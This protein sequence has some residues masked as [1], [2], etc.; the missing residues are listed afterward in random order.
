M[1]PGVLFTRSSCLLVVVLLL[2]GAPIT[3]EP[4]LSAED[5]KY[6]DKLLAGCHFD[7]TGAERVRGEF[8]F[9]SPWGGTGT[10]TRDG[11]MVREKGKSRVYF[12]DGFS[13]PAPDK[14]TAI[15]FVDACKE[16]YVEK[17]KKEDERDEVF[18]RMERT[19]RGV[20]GDSDLSFAVWLHKLGHDELAAKALAVARK[21]AAR[22]A[23]NRRDT[24]APDPR[25]L[26]RDDLAWEAFAGLVHAYVNHDDEL[27]LA[28][29][30]HFFKQYPDHFVRTREYRQAEQIVGELNRRKREGRFG[31]EGKRL[32]PT[33]V[34]AE[35]NKKIAT[36][37]TA[38]D[39]VDARQSGQPG[40]VDLGEDWRVMALIE[41]GE[42]AV[43]AL[44]DAF[45]TDTRLTRSV[46]FWRDFSHSRTVLSV[47]EAELVALMS[48]L[49]VQ[50]FEPA[51]T[52][53][54]FTARGEKTAKE[55]A[56]QLRAYWDTYGKFPFDERMMKILTDPKASSSACR[57]AAEN[58]ATIGNR[59][60][61]GTTVWT[62]GWFGKLGEKANPVIAKFSNPTAAEAMLRALDRELKE[63]A[64]KDEDA[65]WKQR[66]MDRAEE[67]YLDALVILGDKRIALELAKRCTAASSLD[68]RRRFALAAFRLGEPKQLEELAKAFEVGS[69]RLTG[70]DVKPDRLGSWPVPEELSGL[71]FTLSAV[72]TP[73]TDR[74][75]FA[76]AD[77]KHPYHHPTVDV[78]SDR[79][80][81]TDK[82]FWYRHPYWLLLV[83]KT[84]DDTT[85]TGTV[86]K[87]EGNR[88]TYKAKDGSG[89]SGIPEELADPN[90]RKVEASAR[91]CDKVAERVSD[92]VV[93]LP[94]FHLMRTDSE[95]TLKTMKEAIDRYSTRFRQITPEERDVFRTS[96]FEPTFIPS[97]KPLTQA[98]TADDVSS[99]RA[100]FHL[101]G[102]GKAAGLALPAWVTLK[103]EGN[104]D[105]IRGLAVQAEIGP[106]GTIVYGVIFK[107][108]MKTV[109]T[110]DI[111]K[112][113]P[114]KA[115]HEMEA[116]NGGPEKK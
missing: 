64:S 25:E 92:S 3:A 15:N 12:A 4:K 14:F 98:A 2:L 29:G 65:G 45:D 21:Q 37:I 77:P 32:V 70:L 42:P 78:L 68:T 5:A 43:P 31:P 72:R 109:P 28:Y 111:E 113:E 10:V 74:A 26:L 61:I 66:K 39:E 82:R 51:S 16:R 87:I 40:G 59:R 44:I 54:N 57:E 85:P 13:L 60:A 23:E 67:D 17:P 95:D 49:R 71:I 11:W 69:L 81:S 27:A 46:H 20:L 58:L 93:G 104:N 75:L 63:T 112:V 94:I 101:N 96:P 97:I 9:Y 106:E 34:P 35:L 88:L 80:N 1:S 22:Y 115:V 7:P 79:H 99:G 18:D 73:A 24:V 107:H 103:K 100:I 108:E 52:G 8:P 47:R 56:A 91:V 90:M 33:E 41:I 36:L 53:D 110:A 86:Y 76:L 50:V 83:R 114:V 105:P 48:I 55:I 30:T 19:G 89:S 6:L 84:L 62:T 102:K 116:G 38:L